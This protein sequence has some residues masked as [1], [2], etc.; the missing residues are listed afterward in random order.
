[1]KKL[2]HQAS[3]Y[4]RTHFENAFIKEVH[5]KKNE[6]GHLFYTVDLNSNDLAYH[7]EFNNDG[8]LISSQTKPLFEEDLFDGEFYGEDE[9]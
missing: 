1:M 4:V 7:L 8:E 3:T 9:Q 5:E 2:P 6:F